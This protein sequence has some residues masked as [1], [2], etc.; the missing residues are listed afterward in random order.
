M[1]KIENESLKE[2]IKIE[3]YYY[4]IMNLCECNL[5]EYINKRKSQITINE[6]K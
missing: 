5:E 3:E 2:T 6:I 1:K 4:I